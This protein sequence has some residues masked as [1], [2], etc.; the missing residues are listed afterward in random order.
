MKTIYRCEICRSESE[1]KAVVARCEALGR[2]DPALYPP[3][4]LVVGD[5]HGPGPTCK[6]P[7]L[8]GEQRL[9]PDGRCDHLCGMGF[10]WVV[11]WIGVES[12]QPHTHAVRF[13]VF[14]GN[15]CGDSFN[16]KT[17]QGGY[18]AFRMGLSKYEPER[19]F[20][21][22]EDWPEARECPAYWRAVR[23]LREAGIQ[24]TMIRDGKAVPITAE[25]P[26]E[27]E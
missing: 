13:A 26:K 11:Q 9:R 2:P 20:Q 16:F 1:D 21:R 27:I 15:G 17:A 14:R 18:D 5:A 12:F 22:W 8:R 19:G 10:I 7:W 6:S 4:G 23:A 24:P 3:I 25:G